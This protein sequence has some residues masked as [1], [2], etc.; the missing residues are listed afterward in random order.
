[1]FG[2]TKSMSDM[3]SVARFATDKTLQL[4]KMSPKR[5]G[6]IIIYQHVSSPK[7]VK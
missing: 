6:D 3:H 1:M 4:T 7:L 2:M 5:R